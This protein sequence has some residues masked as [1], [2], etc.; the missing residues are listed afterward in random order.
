M[1]MADQT[2]NC[3]TGFTLS[4]RRS[5]VAFEPHTVSRR[6]Q[7]KTLATPTDKDTFGKVDGGVNLG[8]SSLHRHTDCDVGQRECQL[9]A[10]FTCQIAAAI[11]VPN[12]IGCVPG[13]FRS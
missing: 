11:D 5:R 3:K 4:E 12:T 6:V 8:A 13:V 7:E 9:L 2:A 10:L 1:T